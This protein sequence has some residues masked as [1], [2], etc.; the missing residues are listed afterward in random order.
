ML[1]SHTQEMEF[2]IYQVDAFTD[3]CF[4]GNPAAV[5][6]LNEWLPDAALQ[7]IALENNLSE[8]AFFIQK[9]GAFDLRWFTPVTEVNLCGHA[10]LATAHVLWQELGFEK[11]SISFQSKSGELGVKRDGPLYVLDFP[12]DHIEKTGLPEIIRTSLNA[13]IL[14][15]YK[16]REDYLVLLESQAAVEALKPD[17]RKLGE[18]ETRGVIATAAGNDV[19]FISRCF[20]PFFGID[21]DPVT[22]SAHTTLA[23]FWSKKLGKT[24]MTARQISQRG[25]FLKIEL[26]G[27]RTAIA[28]EAVTY[29]KGRVFI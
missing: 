26:R 5:I 23:P 27:N 22:G 14:E 1:I 15:T 12:T 10:T 3:K 21:E 28:G 18:L 8:T 7:K 13:N 6:P 4:G 17:F 20:F 29:L 11:D 19:D 24:A 25:G 9:D 2:D 16:G